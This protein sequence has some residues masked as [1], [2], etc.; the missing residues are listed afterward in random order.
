MPDQK[1]SALVNYYYLRK[2][3]QKHHDFKCKK[4]KLAIVYSIENQN[5]S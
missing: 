2:T 1:I 4:N 5:E 3:K